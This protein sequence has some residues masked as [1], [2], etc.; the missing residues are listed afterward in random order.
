[1]MFCVSLPYSLHQ[2]I[3]GAY[4]LRAEEEQHPTHQK[5]GQPTRVEQQ[6]PEAFAVGRRASSTSHTSLLLTPEKKNNK[7]KQKTKLLSATGYW[8]R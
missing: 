6:T 7:T 8:L 2:Y 3:D 4:T 1:M 5:G